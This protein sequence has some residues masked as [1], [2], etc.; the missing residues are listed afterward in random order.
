[1]FDKELEVRRHHAN[2]RIRVSAQRY[3]LADDVGDAAEASLPEAVTEDHNSRRV[4]NCILIGERAAARRDHAESWKEIS[5]H[6]L[7]GEFFRIIH[8]GQV[9]AL[10]EE[11]GHLLEGLTLVL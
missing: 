7:G 1:M 10:L 9:E 2:D 11:A 8:P 3:G 5:R 4:R 6:D